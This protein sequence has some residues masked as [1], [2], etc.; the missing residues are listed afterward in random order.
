MEEGTINQPEKVNLPS[1]LQIPVSSNNP[2][3]TPTIPVSAVPPIL[4]T[5]LAQS[6]SVPETIKPTEPNTMRPHQRAGSGW[7]GWLIGLLALGLIAGTVYFALR[8]IGFNRGTI[9]FTFEPV[10]AD[11]VVIDQKIR[12]E[13]ISA[14]TITLKVGTHTVQ[15]TKEGYLDFEQTFD[16]ISGAKD[17]LLITLDPI[18]GIEFLAE[19]ATV[20]PDLV[21]KDKFLAFFQPNTGMLKAVDLTNNSIIDLFELKLPNLQ[22]VVWSPSGTA[23]IIKLPEVWRM[24]NMKDNRGVKGQYIPLGESPEQGPALNNGVAT[25][26]IDS[27]R[28]TAKGMQPVLLNESIR[29]VTFS[30]DG[31]QIGYFYTPANGEKSIVRAE[32]IDGS[33]WL[34][35]AV[36]IPADN[37]DLTWLNDERSILLTDDANRTDRLF[38]S[39]SQELIEIMPDRIKGSLVLGSP[40]GGKVAYLANSAAGTTVTI[41]NLVDQTIQATFTQAVTSFVWKNDSTL[42]VATTDNNL[43]YWNFTDA[44]TKPIQFTSAFGALQPQK[45]LYSALT[46]KLFILES[47]RIFKVTA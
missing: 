24:A 20:S 1:D 45:L 25:W 43:W 41:W 36:D 35:L 12:K 6:M 17:N 32:N 5:D 13:A 8:Y 47:T 37:P 23:A 38:D 16:I 21:N 27:E 28:R 31:L 42:I 14:L 46:G 4:P 9:S 33:S 40:E 19:T 7:V 10:G 22:K 18:P 34:R 39:A 26:L 30:P 2:A 15:V 44:K 11:T 3:A 29:D